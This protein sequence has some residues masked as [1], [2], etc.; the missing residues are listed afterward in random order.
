MLPTHD[1]SNVLVD[2]LSG[3][4]LSFDI[5][6]L[7]KNLKLLVWTKSNKREVGSF[8]YIHVHVYIHT[9]KMHI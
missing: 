7:K 9:I 2:F 8:W 3:T 1:R 6:G 5:I 4:K